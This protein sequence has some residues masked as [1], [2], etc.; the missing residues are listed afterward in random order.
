[1]LL[2]QH[3][4]EAERKKERKIREEE[5]EKERKKDAREEKRREERKLKWVDDVKIVFELT[6]EC[7]NVQNY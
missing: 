2:L 3:K 7:E 1:M 4:V 5:R 6:L